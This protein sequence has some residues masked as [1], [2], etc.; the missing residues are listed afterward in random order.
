MNREQKIT[1]LRDE[2]L[3]R[4]V[5]MKIE[6]ELPSDMTELYPEQFL[7]RSI[8]HTE[9][10]V[11][12]AV[13]KDALDSRAYKWIQTNIRPAY[14]DTEKGMTEHLYHV[15]IIDQALEQGYSEVPSEVHLF[16]RRL[17]ELGVPAGYF[18]VEE[19]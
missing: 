16:E 17:K 3:P 8:T 11:I 1:F 13:I 4:L 12:S 9:M 15:D 7:A 5:E 6:G 2:V 14:R 19:V 10:R 18:R